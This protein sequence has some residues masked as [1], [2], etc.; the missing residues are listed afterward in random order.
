L[1]SGNILETA[2]KRAETAMCRGQK[3]PIRQI[4]M[5]IYCHSFAIPE[6]IAKAALGL[7]DKDTA[8]AIEH[9]DDAFFQALRKAE[10]SPWQGWYAGERFVYIY[11]THHHIRQCRAIL[12]NQAPPAATLPRERYPILYRYQKKF[13]KNFPLMYHQ[14]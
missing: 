9:L 6:C 7:G 1:R 5:S 11:Q 10:Y 13:K 14:E 2:K 12:A 8:E 3:I 4:I